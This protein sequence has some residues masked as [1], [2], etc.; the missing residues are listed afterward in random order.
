MYDPDPDQ[1]YI[2]FEESTTT[3]SAC[4]VC[5]FSQNCLTILVVEGYYKKSTQHEL[6]TQIPSRQQLT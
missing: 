1:E 2:Y 5:K 4:D 6:D 3:P